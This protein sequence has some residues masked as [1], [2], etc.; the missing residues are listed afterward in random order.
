MNSP[1]PRR[2][3]GLILPLVLVLGAGAVAAC[4]LFGG[5]SPLASPRIEW[6]RAD[7][8]TFDAIGEKFRTYV[9][10]DAVF[11]N[12][13]TGRSI[14]L[15]AVDDWEARLES[16]EKSLEPAGEGGDD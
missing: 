5:D 1:T 7:R 14:W 9:N 15:S 13:P 8:A 10:A 12:D 16:I 11:A 6:V 3:L 4:Q 2:L